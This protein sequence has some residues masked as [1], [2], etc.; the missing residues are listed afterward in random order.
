MYHDSLLAAIID[1][2]PTYRPLVPISPH[3]RFTTACQQKHSLYKLLARALQLIKYTELLFEM[4][5]RR[6]A[7][8]KTRTRAIVLLELVKY[9]LSLTFT[10]LSNTPTQ[11]RPS[12]HPSPHNPQT[13][14]V[15]S[16]SPARL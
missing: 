8:Y 3:T 10:S 4:G 12:L 16:H 1:N 2:D 6:K 11:G 5:L 13:P 7:S 9:V 14:L 15:P